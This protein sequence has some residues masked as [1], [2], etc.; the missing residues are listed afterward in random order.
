MRTAT[1]L[2]LVV[3]T[4]LLS[5]PERVIAVVGGP[6][7]GQRRVE[8]IGRVLGVRLVLQGGVDV[9]LGPRTRT[10]G[11]AL[12]LTHA[13]SMLPVAALWPAHRRPALISALLATG[14]A[15]LDVAQAGMGTLSAGLRAPGGSAARLGCHPA[16]RSRRRLHR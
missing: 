10:L 12:E 14:I 15:A 1:A 13:G 2:R 9:A 16:C 7:R 8:G 11:V 4:A 3:G 6:D 5:H